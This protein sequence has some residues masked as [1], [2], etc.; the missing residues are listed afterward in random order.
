MIPGFPA[1]LPESGLD[2]DSATAQQVTFMA[3][4]HAV[5]L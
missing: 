3:T 1:D 2:T 5:T 4:G